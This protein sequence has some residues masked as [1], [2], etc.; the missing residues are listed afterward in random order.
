MGF[1]NF[2]SWLKPKP[3]NKRRIKKN[4]SGNISRREF[5]KNLTLAGAFGVLENTNIWKFVEFFTDEDEKEDNEEEKGEETEELKQI[6]E[7]D[8]KSLE[9]ILQFKPGKIDLNLEVAEKIKN[10]WKREYTE[11]KSSGD[12]KRAYRD[13]GEWADELKEIFKAEGV[14]EEYIYLAIPESGWRINAASKRK[15]KRKGKI[16]YVNLAVGPYQFI[17]KTGLNYNL[18]IDDYV[19]ERRDPLLSGRACARMLKDLYDATGDWDLA[20][21]GY[22]GGF[23]WHYLKKTNRENSKPSYEGFL[24]YIEAEINNIKEKIEARSDISQKEKEEL[25]KAQTAGFSQNLNYPQKFQAVN[26][27]IQEQEPNKQKPPI[28]YNIITVK[29]EKNIFKNYITHKG[30]TLYSLGRKFNLS[31][32]SIKKYNHQ[33]Y[34]RGLQA[35]EKINILTN[36]KKSETLESVARRRNIDLDRIKSLNP[37]FTLNSPIPDGYRIK[38]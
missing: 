23:I 29:A 19:D 28:K 10:N 15:V 9:S 6:Q 18:K 13:M 12:L 2:G 22:N 32:E 17:R 25:F 8:I 36:K 31:E 4:E 37:A 1:E 34:S 33:L 7:D 3:E 30:D 16:E 14:P 11:G 20:L 38:V 35:G 26:E 5:L 21:S 24:E 27:L